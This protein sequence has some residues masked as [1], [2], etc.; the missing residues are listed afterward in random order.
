MLSNDE[1]AKQIA[2]RDRTEVRDARRTLRS[3]QAHLT[4]AHLT[5][6]A[7]R[8]TLNMVEVFHHPSNPTA[9]LNYVTPRQNTAWVSAAQIETGINHLRTFERTPRFMYIE[10]LYPPQFAKTL[11]DL[12]LKLERETPLMVYNRQGVNGQAP[13]L[14][15]MPALPDHVRVEAVS[16]LRGVET[17]W[18]AYRNAYYDVLTLGVEP[19]IVSRDLNALQSGVQLDYLL[20]QHE[21]PA[22]VARVSLQGETAHLLAL[23]VIKEARTIPVLNALQSAA[24]RGALDRGAKLVFAPGETDEERRLGRTLGFVNFGSVVCYVDPNAAHE[25]THASLEQPILSL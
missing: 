6:G 15:E 3:I 21:F 19:L 1:D 25:E 23:A 8:E 24:L 4:Q 10:G 11:R 16:D 22:G 7:V 20:I 2:E 5:L 18:Y 17:W 12:N 9:N 13:P 14:P